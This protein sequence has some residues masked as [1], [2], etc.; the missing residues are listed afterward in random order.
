MIP[1]YDSHVP[2]IT[3]MSVSS[4]LDSSCFHILFKFL[5]QSFQNFIILNMI[6]VQEA[7]NMYTYNKW[8]FVESF[9]QDRDKIFNQI[10]M[11]CKW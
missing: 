5:S 4:Y 6:F 1:N 7:G 10:I 8:V 2:Q 3:L 9:G 11:V